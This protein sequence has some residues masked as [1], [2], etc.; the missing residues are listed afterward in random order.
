MATASLLYG[1]KEVSLVDLIR[2]P[3][4]RFVDLCDAHIAKLIPPVGWVIRD[5]RTGLPADVSRK[6]RGT[7]SIHR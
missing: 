1:A 6:V 5:D 4:P 2:E 7:A 3:D